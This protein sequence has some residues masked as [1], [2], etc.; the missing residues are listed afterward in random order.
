MTSLDTDDLD[1]DGGGEGHLDS[2]LRR[3]IASAHQVGELFVLGGMRAHL[4]LH[5]TVPE[6]GGGAGSRYT[7]LCPFSSPV[8]VT[9]AV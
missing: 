1:T 6:G 4:Q 5:E 8:P 3:V 9:G 2:R 7:T